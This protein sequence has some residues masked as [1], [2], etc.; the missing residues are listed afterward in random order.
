MKRRGLYIARVGRGSIAEECGLKAGD[1]I[2]AI[3]GE[4]VRDLIDFRFLEAEEKLNI[5]VKKADGEEWVLEVEKDYD[6]S[7]GIEFGEMGFGRIKRCSNKCVFCF[8]D[9]MPSGLRRSVYVKDDDYRLSFWS[10]S[11]ITLTNLGSKE[12]E[13]IVKQRLSPLYISVHA[14]NPKLR[15]EMLGNP[16]AGLVMEQLRYLAAGGIEMHAQVVLCP[17]LN[18][19]EEL[20]KT[21][22]D[23]AGLWPAVNSLAV[24]PVGLTR[25]RKGLYALRSFNP[26][27]ARRLVCWLGLKQEEYLL[28]MGSP[29]VFPSDEFYLLAGEPVPPAER[30][31][32]FPQAENGVGLT[33]LFLDE[34]KKTE[35]NLPGQ[36]APLKAV[37]ITGVLGEKVLRPI[38]RRLNE[39]KN[40]E[41]SIK[42]IKNYFFGEQVTVA[43]LL[44]GRDLL[45]QI[46]PGETGDVLLLP[47]VMLRKEGAVFLDGLT[48]KG[49]ARRLKACVAAVEGPRQLAR[50]LLE[51]PEKAAIQVRGVQ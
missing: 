21:I 1:W 4:P 48:L 49:L 45:N 8:V 26:E 17:G 44:T 38:V 33:R 27:E 14:T 16:K 46:G 51:G 23:L 29:F 30:Y 12:L 20:E 41:V 39:I 50:V 18:D 43:G 6:Q 13:R 2:V 28:E 40:L 22:A 10:G 5:D 42:V 34:W 32:G 11:F 9:Q 24:V 47:S 15:A 7:L 36:A 19:G 31:A 3:N 37:L 35:K 25:F